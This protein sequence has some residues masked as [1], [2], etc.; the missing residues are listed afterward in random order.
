MGKAAAAGIGAGVNTPD[1]AHAWTA[2]V[3]WI[4]NPNLRFAANY[5]DTKFEDGSILVKNNQG[6]G[7][8]LTDS[9]KA[10]TLRGTFD[11]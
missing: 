6:T 8:S 9:E 2:G 4:V 5:I 7:I 10:L 1:G 3:T 11:F